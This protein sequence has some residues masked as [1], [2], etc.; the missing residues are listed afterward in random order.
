MEGGDRGAEMAEGT[1]WWLC[2]SG[3]AAATRMS[4]KIQ[5]PGL[6][7]IYRVASTTVLNLFSVLS[8]ALLISGHL[9]WFLERNANPQQFPSSYLDGVDDGLWWSVV[10]MVCPPPSLR[11]AG[12]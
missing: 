3:N 8:M 1:P 4:V 2:R 11:R 5:D 9:I 7:V 12:L 6:T 10:T